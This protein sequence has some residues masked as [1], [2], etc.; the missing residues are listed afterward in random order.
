MTFNEIAEKKKTYEKRMVISIIGFVFSLLT[1]IVI[2]FIVLPLFILLGFSLYKTTKDFKLLSNEY[3][4]HFIETELKKLVPGSTFD[5]E[6]GFTQDR[7]FQSKILQKRD[8]YHSEDYFKGEILGKKFESADVHL[9]EVR[10]NGKTTTVVTVFQGRFFV[11]DFVKKFAKNVYIIPTRIIFSKTY[12]NMSRI[13]TE[14]IIFNKRFD[15]YSED[16]QSVFYLLKPRFMEKLLEFSKIAK[17]T[18]FGFVDQKMYVAIDTR[19]DAFDLKMFRPI[20]DNA[21]EDVKS[22]IELLKDL[23]TLIS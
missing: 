11:I 6:K 14:S 21:F 9:Q 3:K 16:G 2:P 1:F 7:V 18:S 10:S 20:D 22:E 12:Q 17:E 13:D 15:V 4:K 19:K 23:I 8:R 5:P